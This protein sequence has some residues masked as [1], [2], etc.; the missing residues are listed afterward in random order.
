MIT[1]LNSQSTEISTLDALWALYQSQSKKVR[2][3]LAKRIL[4][5]LSEQRE[6][7]ELAQTLPSRERSRR[8]Q[9]QLTKTQAQQRMVHESLTRAFDDL[10]AGKVHH[11]A[12]NLFK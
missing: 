8:S 9:H 10:H 7:C 3:A 11:D 1:T 4:A 6:Q 5:E 12:R 2:Q